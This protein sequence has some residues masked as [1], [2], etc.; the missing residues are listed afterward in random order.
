MQLIQPQI[1]NPNFWLKEL[2]HLLP[3]FCAPPLLIVVACLQLYLVHVH[4]LVPW[5]GGGFG[6][7]A[8]VDA[9]AARFWRCYLIT[10]DH[11]VPVRI[12][13]SLQPLAGEIRLM[14]MPEPMSYL[15]SQLAQATWVPAG[16]TPA[17]H[18]KL[19]EGS[20]SHLK[21]GDAVEI[22]GVRLELWRYGFDSQNRQIKAFKILEVTIDKTT[23]ASG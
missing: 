8:S 17:G 4:H 23:R 5:K 19:T 18:I 22:Q 2:K 3:F 10:A 9:P 13:E 12:P 1:S 11:D 21:A 14:P 20:A 6:M 16:S 7:F 15:A